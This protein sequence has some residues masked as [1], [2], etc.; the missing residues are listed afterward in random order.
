MLARPQAHEL[1]QVRIEVTT[2][3]L[4]D[5]RAT[6]CATAAVRAI[7]KLANVNDSTLV[8]GQR[9]PSVAEDVE[10]R[11]AGGRQ[12]LQQGHARQHPV[13]LNK[14]P[15]PQSTGAPVRLQSDRSSGAPLARPQ[16]HELRQVRIELT[17][18]GL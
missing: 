4:G 7:R 13:R 18:L 3:G 11:G 2:L 15:R 5:L 6:S 14:W 10:W 17:T 16:A 9:L 8:C 12:Q 1:R